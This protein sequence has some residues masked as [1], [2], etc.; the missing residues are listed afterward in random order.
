QQVK[1][2]FN[3]ETGWIASDGGYSFPIGDGKVMWTY[4]D[5]FTND[6]DPASKTVPCLFNVLNCAMVQPLNDWDWRHTPTLLSYNKSTFLQSN[7]AKDHFN[8]PGAG[9]QLRDT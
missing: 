4:G 2:F 1:G 5:S 6:Y 3:R 8:W 9:F 7:L